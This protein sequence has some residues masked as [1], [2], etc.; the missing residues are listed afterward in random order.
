MIQALEDKDDVL[1]ID[2][3]TEPDVVK[4]CIEM[5]PHRHRF[6]GAL[7]TLLCP[8][9]LRLSIDGASASGDMDRWQR[10]VSAVGFEPTPSPEDQNSQKVPPLESG[11]LD[12]SATLT[13]S[14]VSTPPSIH[15]TATSTYPTR[16][17][18][19]TTHYSSI[20]LPLVTKPHFL[21]RNLAFGDSKEAA[22]GSGSGGGDSDNNRS[23]EVPIKEGVGWVDAVGAVRRCG[24]LSTEVSR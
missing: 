2:A 5:S 3:A 21:P 4:T 14:V 8:A 9:L 16:L 18:V 19:S 7:T 22:S 10:V 24:A 23:D 12:R 17:H 20:P 15:P 13:V 6:D 11:A 1:A